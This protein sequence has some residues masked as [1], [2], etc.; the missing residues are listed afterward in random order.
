VQAGE[1]VG[2]QVRGELPGLAAEGV[3][4]GAAGQAAPGAQHFAVQVVNLTP[5]S[6]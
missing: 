2:G 1:L 6:A 4:A 5:L 3:V